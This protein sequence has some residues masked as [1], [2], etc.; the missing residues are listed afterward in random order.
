MK[1]LVTVLLLGVFAMTANANDDLKPYAAAG[2]GQQRMVFRLPA[3]EDESSRL[4]EVMVGKTMEVDCNRVLLGGSLQ[5]HS[6]EGW[7]YPYYTAELAPHHATTLMACP[8]D[9]PKKQQFVAA[10]GDGFKI[11]Y[12]SKLPVVVYV[13]DGY[14]VRYRIW[15]AGE[16]IEQ[17][18]VE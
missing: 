2:E 10:V 14:E 18:A 1:Q 9:A 4:V 7:G 5:E 11:R 16:N 6:V 3:L 12:N 17:A 8:P 13:P 15:S